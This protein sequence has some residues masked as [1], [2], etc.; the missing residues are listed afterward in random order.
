MSVLSAQECG[1]LAEEMLPVAARLATIVQGD[2]GREDV[3]ELL[4]RLDLMQTG[5]LAVVLA[6]LVDPDRSWVPCGGG[7]TSTS[8][9]G[10]W[11]R[12]RRTGGPCGRS[13]TRWTWSTR[14]TRSR[15][16]PTR[17]AGG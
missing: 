5:A 3:A 8:T 6:G 11:S 10:R 17:G 12:T 16:P 2:G 7:W 14:S 9:G 15:W 1:D 13:P 4:G